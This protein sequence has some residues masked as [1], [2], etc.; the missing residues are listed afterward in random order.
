MTGKS[1]TVLN[2]GSYNYLG[3]SQNAGP[4]ADE[5]EEASRKYG[6]STCASRQELGTVN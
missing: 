5:V 1:Q 2:L 3:F 6:V 4:C